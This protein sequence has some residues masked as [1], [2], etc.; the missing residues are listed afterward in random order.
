MSGKYISAIFL[1]AVILLLITAV[2]AA[3]GEE[4]EQGPELYGMSDSSAPPSPMPTVTPSPMPSSPIT[5]TFDVNSGRYA[6]PAPPRVNV[7]ASHTEEAPYLS[8]SGYDFTGWNT[9]AGGRGAHFDPYEELNIT[10]LSPL[11]DNNKVRLYGEWVMIEYTV[12]YDPNNADYGEIPPPDSIVSIEEE[13]RTP[14][15]DLNGYRFD[16]WTTSADG[17]G[18][19]FRPDVSMTVSDL[20]DYADADNNIELYGQW[21]GIHTVTFDAAG[22]SPAPSPASLLVP[23]GDT[24]SEPSP[25]PSK[26]GYDFS[27]WRAENAEESYNFSW[28]VKSDLNLTAFWAEK[29]V[30]LNY[31]ASNGTMGN[32]SLTQETLRAV[33]GNASTVTATANAGYHFV[34]WTLDGNEVSTNE[35][36][37]APKNDGSVY[38][39]ATYTANFEEDTVVL[40]YISADE[41][42]GTVSP[43]NET[44]AAVSGTAEG[45]SASA[46]PGYHFVSWTLNGAEVSD[47]ASFTPQKTDGVYVAG[48]YTA[49]FEESV[50]RVSYDANNADYNGAIPDGVVV[51]ISEPS[52]AD[53]ALTLD[54]QTFTGW[55]TAADG[56]GM[57]FD[58]G[59]ELTYAALSPFVDEETDEVTLYAQ[60]SENEYEAEWTWEKIA[61]NDY[62]VTATFTFI[63]EDGIPVTD[64]NGNAVTETVRATVKSVTEGDIVTYTATAVHKKKTY[65]DERSYYTGS[66]GTPCPVVR[67]RVG[68]SDVIAMI[69]YL[70]NGTPL[71]E[72][73]IFDLDGD[74]GIDG[75]D[76]IEL[77]KIVNENGYVCRIVS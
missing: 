11:A 49:N 74:D 25:V 72:D 55:N 10:A 57:P 14:S 23:D 8:L 46:F 34:N 71:P 38:V 7:T 52:T 51:T 75:R 21:T 40:N 43:S 6:A 31:T 68:I 35:S 41:T 28:A 29:I 5:V 19:S 54:G 42:M 1:T 77:E 69:G 53:P 39:N 33:N 58:E 9:D 22:G 67:V 16:G 15:L 59:D 62:K 20:I 4:T 76:L 37:K 47:N 61:K 56:S 24:V 32:V 27:G 44:V 17:S 30:T 65:T 70:V 66:A 48:T 73:I 2:S 12:I 3:A 18:G 13:A 64:E 63:G 45:A 26:S 60:W 50:I 36:F